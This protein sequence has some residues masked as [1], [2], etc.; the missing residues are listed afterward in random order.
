[1]LSILV[2]PGG[3]RGKGDRMK[4]THFRATCLGE[5]H[6]G[7]FPFQLRPSHQLRPSR[8]LLKT[9][10]ILYFLKR[11]SGLT[12]HYIST[13]NRV[14]EIKGAMSRR[15]WSIHSLSSPKENPEQQKFTP[16]FWVI[17]PESVL[18]ISDQVWLENL[19]IPL[20]NTF[21]NPRVIFL[22]YS[23]TQITKIVTGHKVWA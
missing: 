16:Y 19:Q 6:G 18:H 2:S 20:S 13:E 11:N 5:K 3:T 12:C 4:K 17:R 14:E 21:I 7:W 23:I 15:K 10:Q 8:Y 9:A 22:I 1:M